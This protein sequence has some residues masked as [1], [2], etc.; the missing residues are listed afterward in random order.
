M[1][2][3][4]VPKLIPWLILKSRDLH[5]RQRRCSGVPPNETGF[6]PYGKEAA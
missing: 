4:T 1:T 5:H 6:V 3:K 2:Q